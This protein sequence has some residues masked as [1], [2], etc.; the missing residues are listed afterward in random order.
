MWCGAMESEFT[1]LYSYCFISNFCNEGNSG[2]LSA[3]VKSQA[4][5]KQED[6]CVLLFM[7]VKKREEAEDG[8]AQLDT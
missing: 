1:V 3:Y 5:E 6:G 2:S 8:G 4:C 7:L